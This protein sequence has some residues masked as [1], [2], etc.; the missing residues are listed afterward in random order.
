MTA[1]AEVPGEA[2]A[3]EASAEAARGR[4]CGGG[5]FRGACRGSGGSRSE[6]HVDHAGPARAGTA[7]LVALTGGA[8]ASLIWAIRQRR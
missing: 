3:E 5:A 7:L 8:V 1:E 6:D 2:P 4:G